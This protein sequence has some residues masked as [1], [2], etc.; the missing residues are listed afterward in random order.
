[1]ND[2]SHGTDLPETRGTIADAIYIT[3]IRILAGLLIIFS[4]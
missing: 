4:T 3:L 2:S 1:M